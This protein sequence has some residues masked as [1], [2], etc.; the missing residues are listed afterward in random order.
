MCSSHGTISP[1]PVLYISVIHIVL[2]HLFL[3]FFLVRGAEGW[4]ATLG[5]QLLAASTVSPPTSE[6]QTSPFLFSRD[7]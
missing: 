6:R 4:V 1:A 5:G 7:E 2:L 3:L